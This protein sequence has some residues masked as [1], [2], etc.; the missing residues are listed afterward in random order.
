MKQ[1][2]QTLLQRFTALEY[3]VHD[4]IYKVRKTCPKEYVNV[5]SLVTEMLRAHVDLPENGFESLDELVNKLREIKI[6]TEVKEKVRQGFEKKK[7]K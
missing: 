4:Y 5:K 3:S 6:K 7:E 2:V 1:Q